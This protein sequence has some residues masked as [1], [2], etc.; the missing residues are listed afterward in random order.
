MIASLVRFLLTFYEESQTH[1][2]AALTRLASLGVVIGQNSALQWEGGGERGE[3]KGSDKWHTPAI[4][5][6]KSPQTPLFVYFQATLSFYGHIIFPNLQASK[7]L[8]EEQMILRNRSIG[9]LLHSRL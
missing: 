4:L 6:T 2:F 7:N 1:S 9:S 3:R 8:P 5:D